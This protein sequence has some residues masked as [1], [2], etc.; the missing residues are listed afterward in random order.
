[1]IVHTRLAVLWVSDLSRTLDFLTGVL[2]FEPI[3]DVPYGDGRRWVEVRPPGAETCVALAAVE[4]ELLE[5]LQERAGRMAHGW[6]DCD[7][8]DQTVAELRLKGVEFTVEPENAAWREGS[9]WAQ[10]R[11]HDGHLYGLTER[12]R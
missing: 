12:G 9:R 10:I 4:P 8:L 11:G 7:D 6:F 2:G 3:T 5:V 1:M